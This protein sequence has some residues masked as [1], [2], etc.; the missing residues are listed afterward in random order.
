MLV[1]AIADEGHMPVGSI[2]NSIKVVVEGRAL[3]NR[4]GDTNDDA[5]SANIDEVAAAE[6]PKRGIG[7]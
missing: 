6:G 5:N 2:G 3:P 4:I 7:I 1:V